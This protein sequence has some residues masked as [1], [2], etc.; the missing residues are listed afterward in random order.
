M[1][2][3]S[4][5]LHTFVSISSKT[6]YNM[7]KNLISAKL[8]QE[9]VAQLESKFKEI[10]ELLAPYTVTLTAEER[11][12]LPKMSDKTVAFVGKVVD[13]TIS[14]PKLIP[15]MME[16]EELKKDFEANQA[17]QPIYA[18]A[19]QICEMIK[20]TLMATGSEAYTQALLYYASVKMALKLGD[21]EAKAIHEDLG[22]R[23]SGGSKTTLADKKTEN[24][25]K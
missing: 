10:K 25:I 13:Y 12:A 7:S 22:K 20:D 8:P 1:F 16:P 5:L 24:N 21:S 11:M 18:I 17:L 2:L 4:I 14:N 6:S 9:V 19:M 15:P 23:F 3:F